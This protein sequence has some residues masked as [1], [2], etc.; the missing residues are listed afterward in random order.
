MFP[1]LAEAFG[2]TTDEL[3]AAHAA[4]KTLWDIAQEQGKTFEQ[5]QALML[6]ARTSAFE[7][8][9]SDGVLSQEQADWMLE[10]MGGADGYGLGSGGCGMSGG[11]GYGMRGGGRWNSQP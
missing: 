2:L 6:E 5:F 4:G 11:A 8:M 3:A 10:R 9:V 1:A 7:A